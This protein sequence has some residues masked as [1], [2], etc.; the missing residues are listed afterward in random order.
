MTELTFEQLNALKITGMIDLYQA[1][2]RDYRPII[3]SNAL[4]QIKQ[5]NQLQK[6]QS[7]SSNKMSMQFQK[8]DENV[9]TP[10]KKCI[11]DIINAMRE[12]A[13]HKSSISS[14]DIK[15]AVERYTASFNSNHAISK[16]KSRNLGETAG[17]KIDFSDKKALIDFLED[18]ILYDKPL[19]VADMNRIPYPI[20]AKMRS[21]SSNADSY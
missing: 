13:Y 7:I 2:A 1:S 12:L 15:D 17:W 16:T 3:L 18:L 8:K 4:L 11:K 9:L 14:E 19:S 5:Q 20:A 10:A 21:N 6:I